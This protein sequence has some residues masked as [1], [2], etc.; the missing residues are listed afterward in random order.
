MPVLHLPRD[1]TG[2]VVA[3]HIL[4]Q[5]RGLPERMV[6]RIAN[7]TELGWSDADAGIADMPPPPPPTVNV[8]AA[9][10]PLTG[11]PLWQPGFRVRYAVAFEYTDGT[12]V[13]SSCSP[14]WAC[15]RPST[16]TGEPANTTPGPG[17]AR[18]AVP[19]WL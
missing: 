6:A 1:P 7:N 16:T 19:G 11:S 14:S 9:N 17:P 13:R 10:L 12:L 15:P 5:F 2:T 18:A 3:R 4:R 8:W